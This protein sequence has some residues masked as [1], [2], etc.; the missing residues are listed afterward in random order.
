MASSA[1]IDVSTTLHHCGESSSSE[2]RC[3]REHF[4]PKRS[5][6]LLSRPPLL[7]PL[8]PT[9]FGDSRAD[10]FLNRN[11]PNLGKDLQ[12]LTVIFRV[13]FGMH[14]EFSEKRH[15]LPHGQTRQLG[16]LA[17]RCFALS[18]L[19]TSW[20]SRSAMSIRI[21]LLSEEP[22]SHSVQPS[23]DPAVRHS[24]PDEL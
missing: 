14:S 8:K 9:A 16:G 23:A 1:L 12:T 20:I 17:Q 22:K 5:S 13:D 15:H 7:A 2:A 6:T 10:D 19:L 4:Y 3:T 24:F 21:V 18:V 11:S